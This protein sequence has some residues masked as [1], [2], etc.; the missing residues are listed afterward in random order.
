MNDNF[1]LGI[2]WFCFVEVK[3]SKIIL[4]ISCFIF[5]FSPEAEHV[6]NF[7]YFF[8]EMEPGCSYKGCSYKKNNL[9]HGIAFFGLLLYR[10]L[11]QEPNRIW[12][13]KKYITNN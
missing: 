9:C 10:K 1:C 7:S 5:N 4:F 11:E 12:Y 3:N 2:A 8:S 6:L 13:F